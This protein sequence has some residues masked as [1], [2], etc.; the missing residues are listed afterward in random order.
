MLNYRVIV[1]DFINFQQTQKTARTPSKNAP[2]QL[3]AV[4]YRSTTPLNTIIMFVPQQEVSFE[5]CL[6]AKYIMFVQVLDSGANG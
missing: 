4:R 1:N 5:I 6:I 3:M 2:S